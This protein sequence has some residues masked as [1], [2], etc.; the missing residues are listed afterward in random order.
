MSGGFSSKTLLSFPFRLFRRLPIARY[1]T[2]FVLS[3]GVSI[4]ERRNG[5]MSIRKRR[6]IM[7]R[8][9]F[10]V[11]FQG[12][13]LFVLLLLSILFSGSVVTMYTAVLTWLYSSIR[14]IYVVFD[15]FRFLFVETAIVECLFVWDLSHLCLCLFLGVHKSVVRALCS[16]DRSHWQWFCFCRIRIMEVGAVICRLGA[17]YFRVVCCFRVSSYR[18]WRRS[19]FLLHLFVWVYMHGLYFPLFVRVCR[20]LQLYLFLPCF[21]YVA[22]SFVTVMV[23]FNIES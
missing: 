19:I 4:K 13:Y 16:V 20:L 12:Y 14:D 3:T 8:K 2:L 15:G 18:S 21:G 9:Y 7:C 17:N 22:T 6:P 10:F 5:Q 11:S 23:F 1:R